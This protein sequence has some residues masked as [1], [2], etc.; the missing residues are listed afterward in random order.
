MSKLS[1][2]R[3]FWLLFGLCISALTGQVSAVVA[4]S[5]RDQSGAIVSRA[6]VT[7]KSVD[8]GAVRTTLTD[9][10]GFYRVFSL[11]VGEYE[12]RAQKPGFADAVRTGVHLV[13]GQSAAV[14]LSLRVGEASQ[15]VVVNADAP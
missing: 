1:R 14:D 6:A 5:V 3:F 9:D 10:S 11:P 12:V 15:E 2:L 7:V 4:G 13:V 8:T